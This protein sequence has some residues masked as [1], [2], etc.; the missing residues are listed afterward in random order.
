MRVVYPQLHPLIRLFIVRYKLTDAQIRSATQG[1][2]HDGSGL[3]LRVKSSGTKSWFYQWTAPP[4]F[5][6]AKGHKITNRPKMGLG[7]YSII[8]LARAREKADRCPRNR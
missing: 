3:F 6:F 8:T 5:V 2:Y 1:D 7:A 4:H